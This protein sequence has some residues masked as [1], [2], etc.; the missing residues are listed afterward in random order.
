IANKLIIKAISDVSGASEKTLKN[1]IRETGDTGLAAEKLLKNKTQSSLFTQELT[2][3]KVHE[4]LNKISEFSGTGTTKRKLK[5]VE[6]LISFANPAGAK[7]IV[8]LIL[9]ELRLGV[10]EG[11]IRDAIS[12]AYGV[13]AAL[14]ERGYSLVPDMGKIATIA[15]LKGNSGLEDINL[16][17]GTPM[18]VMLAQ[19]IDAIENAIAD[20]G[21]CAYEIKYD[22]IRVQIHKNENEIKLF[23]RRLENVTKQFPEIVKSARENI[24]AE[25]A[26][27]EGEAVAIRGGPAGRKPRPFQDLSRR[28]KRKYGIHEMIDKIPVEINL[29]DLI[30]LDGKSL[31]NEKFMD[32]RI[33][34]TKIIT[35]TKTFRIAEQIITDNITEADEFYKYSLSQGHEGVMV[36]NLDAPYKPG[37]RVGYMYKIKPV[38][39]TL[40]LVIVG[41]TWGEGRRANWLASF[42]LG[43]RDAETGKFLEIGRM[44][45]G[46][47]DEQFKEMTENLKPLI[48]GE[49]GKEVTV[50]PGVVVEVA[51]EEIQKSPTYGSGYALRFPRLVRFRDDK[52]AEDADTVERVNDLTGI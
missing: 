41:A 38:M 27:V 47:T 29:F 43:A 10:G 51:Y 19:K 8:R 23:T 15:K 46:F 40:D 44:G 45:T 21:N 5:Y 1:T 4:N 50:K 36:K 24:N 2:I 31:I 7:Y 37:S 39:E 22:G 33:K 35:Q 52:G 26:I 48:T 49:I 16:E 25:S 32:R 11:V 20:F 28:I 42:L 34:L 6:E 14:V 17:P 9:E 12:S 30:Y 3:N 18:K 13:D